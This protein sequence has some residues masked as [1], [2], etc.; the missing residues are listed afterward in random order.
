MG[1]HTLVRAAQDDVQRLSLSEDDCRNPTR[2]GTSPLVDFSAGLEQCFG[3]VGSVIQKFARHPQRWV[4]RFRD[5]VLY[6]LP[7]VES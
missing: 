4:S 1:R 6:A 3:D 5:R 7:L 2:R